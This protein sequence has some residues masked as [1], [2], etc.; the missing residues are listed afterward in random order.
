MN[1]V[2]YKPL[3]TECQNCVYFKMADREGKTGDCQFMPVTVE[4]L[5]S[6]FCSV[7]KPLNH[8]ELKKY[9]N[10]RDFAMAR[11]VDGV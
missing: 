11:F 5:A 3:K 9:N 2:R 7:F 10:D 6:D 4:K 8:V 1:E